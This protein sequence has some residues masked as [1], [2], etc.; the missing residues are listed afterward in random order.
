MEFPLISIIVPAYNAEK[1]IHRCIDSI[2]SQTFIDFELLI[3]NDGST[4]GTKKICDEYAS[5]DHRIRVF[6]KK[7]GGVSSARNHGLDNA[8]GE[9]IVFVDADDYIPEDALSNMVS[10]SKNDDCLCYYWG[11]LYENGGIWEEYPCHLSP[12][13]YSSDKIVSTFLKYEYITGPYAKLIN[14]CA[15]DNNRFDENLQIGEDL[16]FNIQIALKVKKIKICDGAVYYYTS[17]PNSAMHSDGMFDKY[18]VL[19]N[20][21]NKFFKENNIACRYCE[22]LNYFEIINLTAGFV[23]EP[24]QII[25]K[26]S[27]A[28]KLKALSKDCSISSPYLHTSGIRLLVNFPLIYYVYAMLKKLKYLNRE[29]KN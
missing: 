18:V 24:K 13:S 7:N 25:A 12:N 14:R 26:Y 8:R 1:Y 5:N 16:L 17:N 10:I 21:I 22:E 2:L 29:I 9:W 4:D 3:I 23:R 15:L 28:K 6:H 11:M 19:S 20:C 27:L